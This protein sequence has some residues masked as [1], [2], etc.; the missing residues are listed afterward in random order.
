MWMPEESQTDPVAAVAGNQIAGVVE[1][2]P[3]STRTPGFLGMP[4]KES[5]TFRLKTEEGRVVNCCFE[6]TLRAQL[7]MGDAVVVRGL[8]SK[9]VLN[10]TTI[11]GE[12]GAVLGQSGCFVATVVFGDPR[13]PE[14]EQL[15]LF[16]ERV[17]RRSAPGRA[18]INLY[19]RIG[20]VLAARLAGKPRWCAA[21]RRLALAPLARLVA[22]TLNRRR[23]TL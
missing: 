2:F 10:V 19:W 1:R 7:G 13:A 23:T 21:V 9:G 3:Q 8:M 17:L 20:P 12:G 18:L 5:V 14:V 6:G 22:A 15:R 4:G 11:T 16:R